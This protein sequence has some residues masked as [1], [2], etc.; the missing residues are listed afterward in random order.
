ML[1]YVMFLNIAIALPLKE[2]FRASSSISNI[3]SS[4]NNINNTRKAV[5]LDNKVAQD[6]Q[7]RLL[8]QYLLVVKLHHIY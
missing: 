3:N 7:A 1:I 8:C 4:I 5:I 2:D 6:F